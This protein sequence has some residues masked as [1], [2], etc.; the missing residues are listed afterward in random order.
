MR[1][2]CLYAY[3]EGGT[4]P[5][6]SVTMN[7]EPILCQRDAVSISGGKHVHNRSQ[8]ACA[9]SWKIPGLCAISTKTG[10]NHMRGA[11]HLPLSTLCVGL[12]AM[13][14]ENHHE[15]QLF[16]VSAIPDEEVTSLHQFYSLLKVVFSLAEVLNMCGMR[17]PISSSASAACWSQRIGNSLLKILC[18]PWMSS[19]KTFTRVP[20]APWGE[21]AQQ[22]LLQEE[23][24]GDSDFVTSIPT[25]QFSA[26]SQNTKNAFCKF[27]VWLTIWKIT[28][29]FIDSLFQWAICHGWKIYHFF[30]PCTVSFVREYSK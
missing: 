8:T 1:K 24:T 12:H 30:L 10:H 26:T 25:S 13:V 22:C 28:S 21:Y 23:D 14:L 15:S 16:S 6:R 18:R 19:F 5:C 29:A 4:A 3:W 17:V 7:G 9:I 20:L 27:Q 2:K 11:R